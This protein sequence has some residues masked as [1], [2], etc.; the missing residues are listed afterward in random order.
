MHAELARRG[1]TLETWAEQARA[2]GQAMLDKDR[3]AH[4]MRAVKIAAA[5]TAGLAVA[6]GAALAL[7]GSKQAPMVDAGAS[8]PMSIETLPP[9]T[10]P[11]AGVNPSR[12]K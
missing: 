12:R 9:M 2:E 6:A 7:H 5:G 8:R 10:V 1:L 3:R 4:R 11:D